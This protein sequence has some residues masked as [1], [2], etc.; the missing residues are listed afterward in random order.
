MS[1][2]HTKNRLG[3]DDTASVKDSR[4]YIPLELMTTSGLPFAGPLVTLPSFFKSIV[5]TPSLPSAFF[6]CSSKTPFT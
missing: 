2:W 6:A 5:Q 3:Q 4:Y 1:E